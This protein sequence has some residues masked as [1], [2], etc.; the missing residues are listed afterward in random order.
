MT[1]SNLHVKF[2]KLWANSFAKSTN[3]VPLIECRFQ[4]KIDTFMKL[5]LA[6]A[7]W[8]SRSKGM[9]YAYRYLVVVAI[10]HK[11]FFKFESRLIQYKR[12]YARTLVLEQIMMAKTALMNVPKLNWKLLFHLLSFQ[13]GM[14]P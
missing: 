11:F 4:E 5:L 6:A 3:S 8:T 10:V 12:V 14:V 2:H 13:F 9:F 7:E 1:M